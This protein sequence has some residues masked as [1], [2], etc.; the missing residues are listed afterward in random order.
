MSNLILPSNN[1]RLAVPQNVANVTVIHFDVSV[2]NEILAK[3]TVEQ[4]KQLLATINAAV[5]KSLETWLSV[6][7]PPT[8]A[9]K[10]VPSP[11]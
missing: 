7:N 3:A 5:Q 9:A 1:G 4:K 11:K 6:V 2:K 8:E 10:D